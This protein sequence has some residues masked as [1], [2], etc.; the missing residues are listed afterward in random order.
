LQ[1][2]ER[3]V[4]VV[5]GDLDVEDVRLAADLLADRLPEVR[6]VTM[7]GVAHLP[8]LERPDD[9]AELVRGFLAGQAQPSA[10]G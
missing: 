4:L 6:R 9:V 7:P 5:D 8:A 3:P 2:L 10:R 1:L